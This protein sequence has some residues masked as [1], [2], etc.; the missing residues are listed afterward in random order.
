MITG[1]SK[2]TQLTMPRKLGLQ[3][4]YLVLAVWVQFCDTPSAILLPVQWR[5]VEDWCH[6]VPSNQFLAASESSSTRQMNNWRCTRSD[7]SEIWQRNTE[8]SWPMESFAK[9]GGCIVLACHIVSL[10]PPPLQPHI[11]FYLYQGSKRFGMNID[12]FVVRT[13]GFHLENSWSM[14]WTLPISDQYHDFPTLFRSWTVFLKRWIGKKRKKHIQRLKAIPNFRPK[15]FKAH[16][17]CVMDPFEFWG[18]GESC[19]GR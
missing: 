4:K 9:T 6:S 1:P 12:L 17:L 3:R 2:V 8:T 18:E 10:P 14:L 7:S 5:Q 13:L 11:Y 15:G 16:T 19:C